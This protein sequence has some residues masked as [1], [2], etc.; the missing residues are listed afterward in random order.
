M[1]LARTPT[2][3]N[4]TQN[5]AHHLPPPDLQNRKWEKSVIYSIP[6]LAHKET[7]HYIL[8]C[9]F[10][11]FGIPGED[12]WENTLWRANA[13]QYVH[14]FEERGLRHW[15]GGK[16][17]MHGWQG[18]ERIARFGWLPFS[19]PP[20]MCL[21]VPSKKCHQDLFSFSLSAAV[22]HACNC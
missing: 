7:S 5:P 8:E 12:G 13:R 15:Q 19:N 9:C 14:R 11:I 18:M 2:P 10:S 20:L 6:R 4:P 3:M 1:F 21:P 17:K 16:E 22:R